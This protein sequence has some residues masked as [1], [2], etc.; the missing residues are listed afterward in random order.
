MLKAIAAASAAISASGLAKR[1]ARCQSKGI[2][3]LASDACPQTDSDPE[4]DVIP[5]PLTCPW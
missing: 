3:V 1:S 5:Y 4:P 2:G